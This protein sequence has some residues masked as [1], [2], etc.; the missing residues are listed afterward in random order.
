MKQNNIRIGIRSCIITVFLIVLIAIG[1]IIIGINYFTANKILFSS[2]K[3]LLRSSTQLIEVKVNDYLRPLYDQ[4]LLSVNLIKSGIIDK[5]NPQQFNYYLL[6]LIRNHPQI[7]NV[8]EGE[9]NG[10]TYGLTRISDI[11]FLSTRI[12]RNAKPMYQIE[13]VLDVNGNILKAKKSFNVTYDPRA[14]IWYQNAKNNKQHIW[15]DIYLFQKPEVLGITSATPIYNKQ[16]QF[17]GVFG[18]D[19]TLNSLA[20][21]ISSLTISKNALIFVMDEAGN[22][23]GMQ[24]N[25]YEPANIKDINIPWVKKSFA[26]FQHYKDKLFVYSFKGKKYLAEY[27]EIYHQIKTGE[28]WRAVIIVPM[29]DIVGPLIY[30]IFISVILAFFVLLIGLALVYFIAKKIAESIIRLAAEADTIKNLELA[31]VKRKTA[32]IREIFHMEKAFDAMRSGLQS[33][34]RYVPRT[35]VRKLIASGIVAHVGGDSKQITILFSDIQD[36]TAL[37]ESMPAKQLT[38]FLSGYFERMT[39]IV[40]KYHGTVD[41]YIGDAI[42]AFWGAPLEDKK[43][44]IHACQCALEFLSCLNSGLKIRIGINTGKAVVGNVG[45]QDRLSYTAIG[46]NVNLASRLQELNKSYGTSII[47]NEST[48]N[49]AKDEFEF[50]PLGSVTV[51]GRKEKSNVYELIRKIND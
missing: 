40:H 35:L 51:R 31:P 24:N 19:I 16:N 18:I 36:F 21:F 49:L 30:S 26:E 15:T 48:Y 27:R 1:S 32:Y 10:N 3:Q 6:S 12:Y 42:M 41:K 22:I 11:Q 8:Y 7:I 46:D 25:R 34:A 4:A 37:A 9:D 28:I 39:N 17:K 47:V 2:A 45:S 29:S 13:Q 38:E 50:K 14:R 23:L 43:Q 20:K 44:A 33:F 5:R